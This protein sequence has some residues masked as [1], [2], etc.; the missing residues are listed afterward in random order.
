MKNTD[1]IQAIKS[2]ISLADMARRYVELRSVGSR[3]VAPCPFHQETKPSFSINEE[4]GTFYCFGCQASG[5]IFDFYGR[6][7]GL[8]FKETLAA[9]AEEA[10]I[11]LDAYRTDPHARQQRSQK[12]DMLKMHE[13]A[14]SH[15]HSNLSSSGA[16]A[17]RDYIAERGISPELVEKFGLGW[18]M[19]AWQD[20]GD[21]LRRAGFSLNAAVDCGLQSKSQGG[22]TFDRFRNRLMFPIR[23][24]SGQTI[25]FGGRILPAL[26]KDDDAKYINSSDSP[27]YKK[28]EHLFGLF[29]ARP[30]IAV[31]KSA[32]LTEG[33]MDVITLHQ[34]GYTQAVGVLGT[35]LTPEQIKRLSGFSSHLEL[36]FDGDGAGRKAAF[37]SCEMLLARGLSCKVVLFPDDN[38]I[39]SML[40][41]YGADAVE[42]LR[43]HAQDGIAFCVSVLRNMAPR[44][45]VEWARRFLSQVDMPELFHRF[46]A[47]LSTGLGLSESD[48]RGGVLER[49]ASS[50]PRPT[51][52]R[53]AA[54]HA[55]SRDKEIM[56]FAVRYPHRLPDLQAAGADLALSAPWALKL[57]DKI[58]AY[59]SDLAF[60]ELDPKEKIFWIRCRGEDAPPLD[61]EEGELNAIRQM[62]INLQK[63][64]HMASV[65]AALRQGTASQETQREYMR[66]LLEALGRRSDQ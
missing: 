51:P 62:L 13:L 11:Q 49:R 32:I 1:V 28:G 60:D 25:A 22:R 34:Y 17:C 63:T 18:S 59:C 53:S 42:E 2:R 38:D 36:M 37:R 47:E 24:L 57:W 58:A 9:L 40:H 65:V 19:D 16:A 30:S 27:I 45:A 8:Y 64:S 31:K 44:E 23:N 52:A 15:F 21:T 4:Q 20:L 6:L 26:A 48:L 50:A 55:I 39:D 3:L 12:R 46:A 29:Q 5:D 56:T 43:A 41:S 66:A 33:Y 7:N 14:A 35:A 54:P 61:N 10:G